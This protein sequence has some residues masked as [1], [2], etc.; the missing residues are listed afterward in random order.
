MQRNFEKR[1]LIKLLCL[2]SSS[3]HWQI[4]QFIPFSST[5]N[6]LLAKSEKGEYSA[7]KIS[8]PEEEI[9]MCV[10]I[11]SGKVLVLL[12]NIMF[13]ASVCPGTN[14]GQ[15]LIHDSRIWDDIP[16]SGYMKKF[17]IVKFSDFLCICCRLQKIS[18]PWSN[19][20]RL[21]NEQ[22]PS[23]NTLNST[24]ATASTTHQLGKKEKWFDT[25]WKIKLQ[26]TVEK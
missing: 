20:T 3:L 9:R 1:F 8:F 18:S 12:L 17:Q 21:Q 13:C 25:S 15:G 19:W 5:M 6:I 16:P 24:L 26:N 10:R 14:I 7:P 11:V 2:S 4:T 23:Q 22:V